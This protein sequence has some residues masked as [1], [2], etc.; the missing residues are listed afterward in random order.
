[1]LWEV[2]LPDF[3]IIRC[4]IAALGNS[5]LYVFPMCHCH[6]FS[7][8]K[9]LCILVLGHK[10]AKDFLAFLP[11]MQIMCKYIFAHIPLILCMYIVKIMNKL[12]YLINNIWNLNEQLK[13]CTCQISC[14][15]QIFKQ[16]LKNC[17]IS[18]TNTQ[19]EV[20]EERQLKI[21]WWIAIGSNK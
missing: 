19:H 21:K 7:R 1:M 3:L 20:L 8:N 16:S 12:Y 17:F 14:H 10:Q 2:R 15:L 6:I 9:H 4:V 13:T 11:G 18:D 5:T